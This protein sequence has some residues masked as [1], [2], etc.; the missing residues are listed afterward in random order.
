MGKKEITSKNGDIGV[1]EEVCAA[2]AGH[3]KVG[4]FCL[5]H[6]VRQ[7]NLYDM[8]YLIVNGAEVNVKDEDGF[9][10]LHWA[11][12]KGDIKCVK[13]LVDP[14]VLSSTNLF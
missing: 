3:S 14:E 8:K 7:G 5:H 11:A 9:T 1:I 13:Y 10:P 12:Y 6:A 4:C 2:N